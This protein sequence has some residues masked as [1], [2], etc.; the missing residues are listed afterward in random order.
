MKIRKKLVKSAVSFLIVAII[1]SI[2]TAYFC[3]YLSISNDKQK[4]LSK[5]GQVY[6]LLEKNFLFD[7]DKD[8][9]S[10][11]MVVG[12]IASLEDK[13]A[14]YYSTD[15]F[16]D[17]KLDMEG[18]TYGIG[19]SAIQDKQDSGYIKIVQIH[20]NSP[21]QK[22]GLAV[23]DIIT[24][25]DDK[26]LK[27]V[28]YED[29]VKLIKGDIGTT[30]KLTVL[31]K[32]VEKQFKVERKDIELTSVITN[33]IDDIGYVKITEFRE[34]TSKQFEDKINKLIKNGVK[35]L[36]FD[37]RNNGGG[38]MAAVLDM[39]D[40]LLPKGPLTKVTDKNK[41]EK[42]YA[43]SDDK[44]IDL[45]MVTLTNKNTASASEL[46][47]QVL[48][49][50]EKAKSVGEKSFGKGIIQTNYQLNDNSGV[51]FTTQYFSGPYSKNF[52]GKGIK[53]DIE[54]KMSEE[55]NKKLIE[56][57]ITLEEDIQLQKAIQVLKENKK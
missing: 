30:V 37:I 18:H 39:M 50:Y 34:S 9:L 14:D 32:N 21:A 53:P 27:S 2:V 55:Q 19:I 6:D 28:K 26:D 23:G 46:F 1:S 41:N 40:Y 24:K 8:K 5:A 57:E 45:P 33:Q 7:Y 42:V 31:R 35:G 52:H 44:C 56:N 36:V 22:S 15:M 10:D 13:Y 20:E 16:N 25:I 48:K 12:M 17:R 3:G 51:K 49:D 29:G 11:M 54:I 38:S 47:V 4:M 43:Y